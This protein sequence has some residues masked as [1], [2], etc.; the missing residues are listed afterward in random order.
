[1]DIKISVVVPVY[2]TGKYLGRCMDS[3]TAQTVFDSMEI[4]LVDD[5]S[6]GRSSCKCWKHSWN[7]LFLRLPDAGARSGYRY[8][9]R[10]LNYRI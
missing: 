5:G 6:S 4:I 8:D 9:E 7:S 10:Y 3:L 2:K 1:M